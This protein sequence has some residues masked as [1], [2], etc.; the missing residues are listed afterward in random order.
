MR[1]AARPRG[2]PRARDP[3]PPTLPRRICASVLKQLDDQRV[4]P[5]PP[6]PRAP[7]TP[8]PRS[9]N[10]VQ[11]I[12]VKCLGVL[13]K[14]VQEAQVGEISD[15]LCSLILDG[16]DEL[17]DIYSI[18][19]K[20]LLKD[21]PQAMGAKVCDGLAKRLLSGVAQGDKVEVKLEALENLT[22]LLKR[23]GA[24]V[25]RDHGA[26]LEVVLDQ[27]ADGKPVVR[28]RSAGCL[29][30]L[31]L[32]ASE[33]LLEKLF[34]TLLARIQEARDD[35]DRAR[36]LIQTIGTIS[37]AVGGRLGRHLDAVVPVFVE[38]VGDDDG[39]DS[40]T[41][42][43]NELREN[44]FQG[45]ESFVL[46]CPREI[47]PHVERLLALS[48]KFAAFDPNYAYD[49]DDD[50]D[51][52]DE[53]D[54]DDGG[55]D[56]DD[57]GDDD[58]DDDT[59]WKVRRA[60]VRVQRAVAS[61]RAE[62]L[63]QLY[64]HL[65]PT[66]VGRF[67]EREE[68]VR[69]D[70]IDAVS[71]LLR[72]SAKEAARRARPGARAPGDGDA[73][74]EDACA[75]RGPLAAVAPAAVAACL[76][77]VSKRHGDAEKPKAACFAMLRC[78][79]AASDDLGPLA[80]DVVKAA[81][82]GF[83]ERSQALRLDA[84]T[85]LRAA[86]EG[87]AP[88]RV[89]GLVGSL[90]PR[91]TMLVE[92]DWYK[93]IAEGLRLLSALAAVVRPSASSPPGPADGDV[94]AALYA[95]AK[96]RL[97]THDIDH[98]IKECAIDA[99]GALAARL[100]DALHARPGIAGGSLLG[101]ALATLVEKLRN[102]STRLPALRALR[103]AAEATG[104]VDAYPAL[105]E[106]L[107]DLV[108]FLG[109]ASRPLKQAC[110]ETLRALLANAAVHQPAAVEGFDVATVLKGAN[111]V[112]SD[113]D[114]HLAHLAIEV[115]VAAVSAFA[116]GDATVKTACEETALASAL[117][118]ACSPLL[119]GVCLA[120]LAGLFETLARDVGG[121]KLGFPALFAALGAAAQRPR[122]TADGAK[123]QP[124]QALANVACVLA[125][126]CAAA[127]PPDRARAVAEL[128]GRVDAGGGD[129]AAWAATHVA[130]KCL[131][132]LGRR[133]D[134]S[135]Y[136]PAPFGA[137]VRA[138][139]GDGEDEHKTAAAAALGLVTAGGAGAHLAPLLDSLD[140]D[141]CDKEYLLLAA[142]REVVLHAGS[143]FDDSTSDRVL[144][145]LARS[146]AVDEEPTRNMVAECAGA[147]A[148]VRPATVCE[149]FLDAGLARAGA[150][151]A[152]ARA[153]WTACA[154]LKAAVS[155][156]LQAG[157]RAAPAAFRA[158]V[159]PRLGAA[160][161]LLDDDDLD[162]R[163]QCL[164]M[165]NAA[166]HHHPG[167]VAPRLDF[168][169]P[170]LATLAALVLKRV[171]DLGP[172]KH[173]VDDGL[174]L[175]KAALTVVGTLVDTKHA[176]A[177]AFVPVVAAALGDKSED[178]AMMAHMLLAKLCAAEPAECDAHADAI[179]EPLEKT[180]HKKIK[181][182]KAAT[183]QDRAYDLV[184]SGL[185]AALAMASIPSCAKAA[186]F[187]DKAKTKEKLAAEIAKI[188]KGDS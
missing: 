83:G 185:K 99:V 17:R 30:A 145:R 177:K 69:V 181:E 66:L 29:A 163:K 123:R 26:I 52:A 73:D 7:P 105:R 40:N 106:C 53:A 70:V 143:A 157:D 28:K 23:F 18:G 171:V 34:S 65:A 169:V 21:V 88:E 110:L 22:D 121:S 94:A 84:A 159:A 109:Q 165:A 138:L 50:E 103:E 27:L 9:S 98:E 127:A 54:D 107:Q 179:L 37:R 89:S 168:V 149:A 58:D 2:A 118:L 90:I 4:A 38:H 16:K 62:L 184:R 129:D 141:P 155:G 20:T 147:L 128:V 137:L 96:P 15:K 100:G 39:E 24:E 172:F 85:L 55:F 67:K 142:L 31:A 183:E 11:S 68:N 75:W 150:D 182:G 119:Q 57:Y 81:L 112:V 13:L 8:R 43:L 92:A 35:V 170:R 76:K 44:C 186:A 63:P 125:S 133:V 115:D 144:A 95:A 104:R 45:L 56:D 102:E 48:T 120:S 114:L 86:L 173:T 161:A 42:E 152:D 174:P 113:D 122:A 136:A 14:K 176:D 175:R 162:V 126:L 82:Y 178:V 61:S 72:A 158:A 156:D 153:R 101:D 148:L 140:A 108:G 130:T 59:S 160:L 64:E 131:G 135:T 167:L 87:S 51:M 117:A 10:D 154:A 77:V 187:V 146:A 19:L 49:D 166:A 80:E 188:V 111:D 124:R 3:R 78:L 60:A 139:D 71:S 47:A 132:E 32:F 25:S 91:V 79:V 1:A 116:K 180:V 36:T 41:E 93:L 46:R 6:A 97:E 134:L 74:M 33:D 12:A 164:V 5:R 151:E